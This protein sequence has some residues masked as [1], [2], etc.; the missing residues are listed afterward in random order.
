MFVYFQ[1][2]LIWSK[3]VFLEKILLLVD[4]FKKFDVALVLIKNFLDA[5]KKS[6]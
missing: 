5:L 4:V 6:K 3:K 2:L 1:I